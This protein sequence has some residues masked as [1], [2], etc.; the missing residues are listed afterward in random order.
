MPVVTMLSLKLM[1]IRMLE[2]IHTHT[3]EFGYTYKALS[4]MMYLG[5]RRFL[6]DITPQVLTSLKYRSN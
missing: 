1:M 6:K 5:R 3:Q 2:Y 4:F